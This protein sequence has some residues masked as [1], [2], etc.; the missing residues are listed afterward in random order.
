MSIDEQLF[1]PVFMFLF[2]NPFN[3]FYYIN[4]HIPDMDSPCVTSTAFYG[5]SSYFFG[6]RIF[7]FENCS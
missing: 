4:L 7:N 5:N 1:L 6:D 3:M 2:Q